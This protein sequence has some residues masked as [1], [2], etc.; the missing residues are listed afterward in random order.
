MNDNCR[1]IITL[2]KNVDG[3]LKPLVIV[4][5]VE[6]MFGRSSLLESVCK[7]FGV[8][9]SEIES[10]NPEMLEGYKSIRLL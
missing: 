1:Y 6:N 8:P 10:G 9:F 4:R 3:E 7:E 2:I 5:E